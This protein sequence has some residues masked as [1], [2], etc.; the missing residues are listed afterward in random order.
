MNTFFITFLTV[1]ILSGLFTYFI[2]NKNNKVIY[3]KE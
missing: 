1:N 3:N 2:L